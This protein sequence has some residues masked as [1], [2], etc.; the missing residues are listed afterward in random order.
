M[1]DGDAAYANVMV[2]VLDDRDR[3]PQPSPVDLDGENEATKRQRRRKIWT[4]ARL[5]MGGG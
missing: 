1:H 5:R 4:P 3:F 2:N